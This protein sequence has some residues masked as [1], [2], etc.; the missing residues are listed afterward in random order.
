M[1]PRIYPRDLPRVY[2]PAE[3]EEIA[4]RGGACPLPTC[5]GVFAVDASNLIRRGTFGQNLER[6]W[7]DFTVGWF[8]PIGAHADYRNEEVVD[9]MRLLVRGS[10]RRDETPDD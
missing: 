2:T 4:N 5:T 7:V 9:L 10:T 1:T 3:L 6:P 8:D